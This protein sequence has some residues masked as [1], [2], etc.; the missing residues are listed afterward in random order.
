MTD[1]ETFGRSKRLVRRSDFQ[2]LFQEGR[3]FRGAWMVLK[4]LPNGTP[5]RRFGCTIRRKVFPEAVRRN[6]IKRWL[7]E[8]FRRNQRD[9]QAGLDYLAVITRSP[10][11]FSFRETEKALLQLCREARFS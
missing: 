4:I 10:D 2:R 6:R 7:R 5:R 3:G 11:E 8:A 1:S 9:I